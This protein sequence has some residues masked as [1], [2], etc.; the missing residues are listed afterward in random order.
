METVAL[1]V[2]REAMLL[3]IATAKRDASDTSDT[4]RMPVA[5]RV[6]IREKPRSLRTCLLRQSDRAKAQPSRRPT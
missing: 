3:R 5:I 2:V 1:V 4:A 6:S